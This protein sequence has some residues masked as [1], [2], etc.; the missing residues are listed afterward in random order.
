MLFHATD[1]VFLN[2]FTCYYNSN[3]YH[4]SSEEANLFAKA[5]LYKIIKDY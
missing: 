5:R 3:K 1:V 2:I 4:I